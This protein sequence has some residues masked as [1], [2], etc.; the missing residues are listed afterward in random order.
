MRVVVLEKLRIKE[1][2]PVKV[3][4][5][6]KLEDPLL[7]NVGDLKVSGFVLSALPDQN[8]DLLLDDVGDLKLED[9]L[10]CSMLAPVL[11]L[12]LL[13]LSPPTSLL[14]SKQE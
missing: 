14:F 5:N 13:P 1:C 4:C 8:H 10:D 6:F 9:F 11:Y 3:A 2:M 7:D 12:I